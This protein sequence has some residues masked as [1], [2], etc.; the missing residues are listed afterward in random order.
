[1]RILAIETSCD[2][3]AI[4]I[5]EASGGLKRPVFKVLAQV[6]ASQTA[7]HS[8]WGG[9]VPNLAK[10]EHEQSIIPLTGE[11]LRQAGLLEKFQQKISPR[12]EEK[13]RQYL[14]RETA[15]IEPFLSFV[16]SVEK[17]NIDAIAVTVGPGLEP[18]LWVGINIARTLSFIWN[19]PIIPTNHMEGHMYSVLAE[20][21]KK[22]KFPAV[23]LLVS[24]GHTELILAK[25]YGNYHLLGATRDDA[26]GEAFDKVARILSL[27]YP[28]G[29][30]ISRLA[31][32]YTGDQKFD[33]PRPMIKSKDLDFSFSGLK[34]AVLYLVKKIEPLNKNLRQAIS[35]EFEEAVIEVLIEKSRSAISQTKAK[36]LV[37]GGGVIANRRLREAATKLASEEKVDLQIPDEPLAT[38]NATM[39]GIAA[40]LAS[41]QRGRIKTHRSKII[42]DGNLTLN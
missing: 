12:D 11:A 36:T 40:Y 21:E 37:V 20:N 25:N 13:I 22:L 10:R 17:P 38:D 4:S 18:A 15:A 27:P 8:P 5:I 3:T 7:I 35:H 28:G 16:R 23:A 26:V 39:I 33:L 34:T 29:P 31:A 14:I 6:I 41:E 24:G 42:A 1:M 30:E 32:E 19:L 9:V 2:E